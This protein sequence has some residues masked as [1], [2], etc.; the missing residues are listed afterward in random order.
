MGEANNKTAMER[1]IQQGS[2]MPRK[3]KLN[4]D[5]VIVFMGTMNA[6]PMMYALELKKLGYEVIYFVDVRK[7]DLLSRPENHFPDIEYPYPIWVIELVLPSQI[8]LPIF[9]KLC[10]GIYQRRIRQVTRKKIGCFV[11][12]GFFSSLAPYLSRSASKVGLPHGSDLDTWADTDNVEELAASF[13]NRS[14]FKFLPNGLGKKLVKSIVEKQFAGY[15]DS[16]A[17]AYFPVGFNTSGDKVLSRLVSQGVRHT[18]RY[19]ISFEVLKG[20]SKEFKAHSGTINIFSGVRFLYKTFSEG[21]N[22][23]NKGNDLIIEGIAKYYL[24][25]PNIQVHFI[26]KGADVPHAKEMCRQAGLESVVVWHQ[27][28][29]LKNLLTLYQNSDVCFDQVGQHWIGAIGGY[30]MWLGKPLIANA[31]PAVRSGIWPMDNPVCSASTPEEIFNWLKRLENI[32]FRKAV[33]DRSKVFVETYM[34]PGHALNSIFD[35]SA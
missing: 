23:Y 20:Q 14:I 5:E 34:G 9:P 3:I 32:E 13:K 17:I 31:Q 30:A 33:S 1:Q 28:M 21:N 24:T 26:E 27:E 15:A 35:V 6:M 10:A 22:G 29:S 7:S 25:N 12:S 4:K 16:N 11:L 2:M 18:P 19:D 8:L